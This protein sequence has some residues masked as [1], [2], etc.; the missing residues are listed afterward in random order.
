LKPRYSLFRIMPRR[1]LYVLV[2]L[3]V[4]MAL[5]QFLD[6]DYK[7]SSTYS[8]R[9]KLHPATGVVIS[10]VTP[11]VIDGDTFTCNG[12]TI[13]L[14]GIDAPE[15]PGHCRAGRSCTPGDPIASRD[16]LRSL[17]SGVVTCRT[18]DTD[19]YG[20]TVALCEAGGKDLSC[21]M[22]AAGHAARR[23]RSLTCAD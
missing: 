13:R 10:C 15:M 23:Y 8:A 12:T 9:K 3:V 14:A 18:T 6:V 2:A 1:K 22:V 5:G 17:S 20:R 16:Y 4:A 11:Y 19:S 7:S 21:A